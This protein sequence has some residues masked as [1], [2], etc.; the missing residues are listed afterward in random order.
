[1]VLVE[2][3]LKI[4]KK[5]YSESGINCIFDRFECFKNSPLNISFQKINGYI[6]FHK[7]L[8]YRYKTYIQSF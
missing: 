8:I 6:N 7:N 5:L 2:L 4:E 1:M 3:D